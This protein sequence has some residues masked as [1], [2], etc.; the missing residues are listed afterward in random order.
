MTLSTSPQVEW[1]E[2][3]GFNNTDMGEQVDYTE[4]Q[5]SVAQ[6]R[7][8]EE[9]DSIRDGNPDDILAKM[10]I[11]ISEE[12]MEEIEEALSY[13]NPE[14]S[15]QELFQLQKSNP[16]ILELVEVEDFINNFKREY[17]A[18]LEWIKWKLESLWMENKTELVQ[19]QI[20]LA[21][22]RDLWTLEQIVDFV[23]ELNILRNPWV[24]EQSVRDLY[25]SE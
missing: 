7:Q 5:N 11:D 9:R 12:L 19:S 3:E 25:F 21:N 17:I 18:Y 6:V 15:I 2:A 4:R 23:V 24:T 20:D 10:D 22:E 13:N 16:E 1:N 14:V 8:D